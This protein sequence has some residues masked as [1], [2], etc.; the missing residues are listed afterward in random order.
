MSKNKAEDSDENQVRLERRAG[1]EDKEGRGRNAERPSQIS[2]GGWRDVL[3]RV[4]AEV[5]EDRVTLIAAGATFYLLLALFPALA[6]F[7]S[8]Y[9]F[10]ADPQTI[11]EHI[12]F[13]GGI[14]PSGGLELIRSQLSSL[15]A[16]NTGTLSFG[17]II[18]L[19]VALWSANSGIKTLFEAMNIAYEET[20]KRG[21]IHLNLLALG[22]TL[23][24]ILIG[25]GLIISVGIV[26]AML[27]LLNLGGWTETL[28]RIL[29]WPVLLIMVGSGITLIYRYGPSR[30][31][32]KWRWATWGAFLSAGVW[33]AVSVGFSFYLENFANYNVT[34]GALGTV[35]GF[36]M[37]T[38]ISV[39]VLI[40]GAE[41]NAEMEHQTAKDTTTGAQQPMGARGATVA[42]TLGESANADDKQTRLDGRT[43]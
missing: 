17:F 43:T 6:A 41:L 32:A 37:W 12:S 42:D 19:A 20:E 36:M 40:V 30:E 34:Y 14:L 23:G 38:W 16:Q 21:F 2:G 15:A 7:V 33:I 5:T 25:I 8:I 10:V 39:I 3:W 35:I 27:A 11:A 13:L 29:R 24:A 18:G 26:P 1:Q 28:V 4:W 22:F 31:K 9:G